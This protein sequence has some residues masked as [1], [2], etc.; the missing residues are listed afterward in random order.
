MKLGNKKKKETEMHDSL[1]D[2]S[3][4]HYS[5]SA[6]YSLD[7][8][9]PSVCS[10]DT[11]VRLDIFVRLEDYL[12]SDHTNMQC[13]DLPKFCD[14]ILSWINSSSFKISINGLTIIQLLVQR[15]T[16]QLRNHSTESKL[17]LNKIS[18]SVR[19]IYHLNRSSCDNCGR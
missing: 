3:D 2:I 10:K 8:F 12:K 5:S 6:F 4:N 18:L 11:N 13:S 14:A 1:N 17:D 15:A 19:P 7:D 16:E 9:A